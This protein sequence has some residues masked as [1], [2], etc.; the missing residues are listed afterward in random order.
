M[1]VC[2]VWTGLCD[3]DDPGNTAGEVIVDA[4]ELDDHIV[5]NHTALDVRGLEADGIDEEL[6]LSRHQRVVEQTG[7][8]PD[9]GEGWTDAANE[10]A[11]DCASWGSEETVSHGL[12]RLLGVVVVE[13][14]WG[15]RCVVQRDE[16]LA[17]S[18]L[19]Y[20]FKSRADIEERTELTGSIAVVVVPWDPR[21]V[22]GKLLEVGAIIPVQLSVEIGE[23]SALKKG[24]FGKVDSADQMARLELVYSQSLLVMHR[25]DW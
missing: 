19:E 25:E 13:S 12:V 16:L 24:I 7:L 8:R 20:A 3:A 22:D 5:F 4:V 23:D 2:G 1:I 21:A 9:V 18:R 14:V 15:V 6:L 10:G 17:C 11:A